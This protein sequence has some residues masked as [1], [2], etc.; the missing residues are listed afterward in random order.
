[1]ERGGAIRPLQRDFRQDCEADSSSCQSAL[2]YR[3]AEEFANTADD[4]IVPP[5]SKGEFL[6]PGYRVLKHLRR[7]RAIDTYEVWSEERDCNCVAKA[8]RPDRF[9]EIKPRR[10]LFREGRILQHISHPHLVRAYETI[11]RPHPIVIFETLGGVTLEGLISDFR[12]RQRYLRLNEIVVLGLHLCSAVGYLHRHGILHLDLKPSNVIAACGVAKVID[13]SVSGHLGM[14]ARKGVGTR[15]YLAPEQARGGGFLREAA[16]VW[17]I[18]GILFEAA[19]G[20]RAFRSQARGPKY[21]QLVR[22][23]DP[24]RS[25]RRVPAAFGAAVDRCLDPDPTQ[26][27]TIEELTKILN[28]LTQTLNPDTPLLRRKRRPKA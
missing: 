5:L 3:T 9:H 10:R 19:T 13:L 12:H 7:G 18:G 25:K 22:R 24:V 15:Q 2:G 28:G 4:S 1:M 8:L 17:G 21:Q 27:P 11:R 16:D 6:A 14:R 26:C 23:A 20:R